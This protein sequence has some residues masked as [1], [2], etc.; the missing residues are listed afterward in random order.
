MIFDSIPYC[1]SLWTNSMIEPASR[2]GPCS[3]PLV[4]KVVAFGMALNAESHDFQPYIYLPGFI[5]V[6]Q[7]SPSTSIR[8]R[9]QTGRKPAWTARTRMCILLRIFQP[10]S[11][12]LKEREAEIPGKMSNLQSVAVGP[13]K[14]LLGDGASNHSGSSFV[15]PVECHSGDHSFGVAALSE[16]LKRTRSVS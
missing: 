14:S 4:K 16:F 2:R 3:A 13:R 9:W 11:I 5:P 1:S 12:R 15:I 8:S 6:A 7:S 10:A